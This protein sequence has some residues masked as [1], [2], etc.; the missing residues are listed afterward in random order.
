M[1]IPNGRYA[2]GR[3]RGSYSRH[4]TPKA[5]VAGDQP[6]VG[7][8]LTLAAGV[9]FVLARQW[10]LGVATVPVAFVLA[11]EALR[12]G[13]NDA[14]RSRSSLKL[15]DPGPLSEGQNPDEA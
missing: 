11:G 12:H 5:F 10:I 13:R 8:L 4:Q 1:A 14:R 15:G 7:A 6:G 2:R 3:V 9:L